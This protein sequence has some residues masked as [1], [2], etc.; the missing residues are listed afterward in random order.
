MLEKHLKFL[1]TRN[2]I[3]LLLLWT[4]LRP[5]TVELLNLPAERTMDLFQTGLLFFLWIIILPRCRFQVHG[6]FIQKL[7]ILMFVSQIVSFFW[8]TIILGYKYG[9]RDFYE[10]YRFP[11]LYLIYGLIYQI[12]IR[13]NSLKKYV[14]NP[15]ILCFAVE[16]MIVIFSYFN[17][18]GLRKFVSLIYY[19]KYLS[20]IQG[21][22]QNTNWLGVFL[23]FGYSFMMSRI[24]HGETLIISIILLLI[25][26]VTLIFVESRTAI[27]ALLSVTI[28]FLLLYPIFARHKFKAKNVILAFIITIVLGFF[29]VKY[30][31]TI[32]EYEMTIRAGNKGRITE[33]HGVGRRLRES[34]HL[35]ST[36]CFKS[37]IFGYGPSK[38]S[39]DD[40]IH[41]DYVKWFLR[42]GI[43]GLFL[44]L[45]F[46]LYPFYNNYKMTIRSNNLQLKIFGCFF[47]GCIVVLLVSMLAGAFFEVPQIASFFLVLCAISEKLRNSIYGPINRGRNGN[48]TK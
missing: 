10:F 41:N 44:H 22:F 2:I 18:F 37:P 3:P 46:F 32:P 6:D 23:L 30:I 27:I 39:I 1:D 5:S 19:Q 17:I 9:I 13:E 34:K 12:N 48:L 4:V 8:G 43:I 21:T 25:T 7:L 20:D 35:I 33:I 42:Y 31:P 29:A 28:Y 24:L 16:Y 26:V 36:Y 40:V 45:L 11:Y 15:I 14:F 47:Q 38:Y